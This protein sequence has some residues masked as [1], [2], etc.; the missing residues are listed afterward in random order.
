[1]AP[2]TAKGSFLLTGAN[3]A[4][5]RSLISQFVSKPEYGPLYHGIYVVRDN[6]SAHTLQS[7]L[8]G[9]THSYEVL[10]LDLTQCRDVRDFAKRLNT[11]V[12][13][14]QIPPLRGIVLNAAFLE[15]W[16]QTWTEDGFDTSF[17]SSYLGHW[18]LTLMLL[19]SLDRQMGRVVVVGSAVHDTQ[20]PHNMV[21]GQ[22]RDQKWRQIFHDSTDPIARGYWSTNADDPSLRSGYRRYGAAKLC[23]VMMIPE[24]QRRLATDELL[25]NISIVGIDPGSTPSGITRRGGWMIH[26]FIGHFVMYILAAV[27]ALFWRNAEIRTNHKSARGILAALFECNATLGTQPKGLY[28][29][30]DELVDM[31]AEAR[32]HKKIRILWNDTLRY[33]G[34]SAHE[35]MLANWE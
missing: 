35:T 18:L 32:D 16:T 26:T 34:L 21:G 10:V 4:I 3:G 30:G 12:S 29:N 7:F 19:Q 15:L 14:G 27:F 8:N 2:V 6:S 5:G 20:S 28:M 31:G 13:N 1:M 23:Q 11:R 9:R 25:H 17:A 33:T 22:Y 24:L